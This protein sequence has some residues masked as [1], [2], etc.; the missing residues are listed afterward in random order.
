MAAIVTV[1]VIALSTT[2]SPT[3]P[4]RKDTALAGRRSNKFNGLGTFVLACGRMGGL[5]SCFPG[6]KSSWNRLRRGCRWRPQCYVRR[7]NLSFDHDV[8]AIPEGIGDIGSYSRRAAFDVA[9]RN[10]LVFVVYGTRRPV[11]CS[12]GRKRGTAGQ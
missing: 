3:L 8:V 7:S 2:S 9:A 4:D 10:T 12:L 6:L 11:Y 5:S 1:S